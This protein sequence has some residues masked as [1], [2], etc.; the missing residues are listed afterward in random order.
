MRY[1][2]V[3]LAFMALSPSAYAQERLDPTPTQSSSPR[4][5]KAVSGNISAR[6]L[7]RKVADDPDNSYWECVYECQSY[8]Q[9]MAFATCSHITNYDDQYYCE[10]AYISQNNTCESQCHSD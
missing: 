10:Q 1:A 8:N 3:V 4:L 9:F 2:F 5:Q 6:S 7:L